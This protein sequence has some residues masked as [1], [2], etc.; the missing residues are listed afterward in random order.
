MDDHNRSLADARGTAVLNAGQE[1]SR[2][3]G[4]DINAF[5]AQNQAQA[6]GFG[7]GL[8]NAGLNNQT[9]Q[10]RYDQTLG[11]AGFGNAAQQQNFQNQNT[12]TGLN[13]QLGDQQFQNQITGN[14]AQINNLLSLLG[15]SQTQAP[16]AQPTPQ[17]SV[18]GTDVAGNQWAQYGAQQNQSN[19][20]WNGLGALGGTLGG[21]LFSDR[22]LK[23]DIEPTGEETGRGVPI[24]TWRYKGSPMLQRGF[25]AQDVAKSQ[26]RA[27]RKGP[28]GFL[29]VAPGMVK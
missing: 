16:Q 27:V 2:M 23:T 24:K 15:G 4:L 22:R 20:L 1:Q 7:Q 18:A 9:Q 3:Q 29:M 14:S 17:T 11:N 12:T 13:N 6:Q 8:S 5:N 10:Q 19:Q 26:P 28:G 21:F 25:V